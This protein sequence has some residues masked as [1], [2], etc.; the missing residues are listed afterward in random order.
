M[1][2]GCDMCTHGCV[3]GMIVTQ[4]YPRPYGDEQCPCTCHDA[5]RHAEGSSHNARS[6]Q[7]LGCHHVLARFLVASL[8]RN[9]NLGHTSPR[10]GRSEEL[11]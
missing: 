2:R 10:T 6:I 11:R 7:I 9:D 8:L 5:K 1:S 4:P 3:D